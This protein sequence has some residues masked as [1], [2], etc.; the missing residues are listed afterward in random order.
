MS[1][2]YLSVEDYFDNSINSFCQQRG[3]TSEVGLMSYA[4]YLLDRIQPNE[5]AKLLDVGCGDGLPMAMI[6]KMRPDLKIDGLELSENL[7]ALAKENNPEGEIYTGNALD[8]ALPAGKY[9]TIFSF[10]FLQY[11]PLN[12]VSVVQQHLVK[13]IISGGGGV[14]IHCSIPDV[15]MQPISMAEYI[16]KEK[17]MSGWWRT[18]IAYII[19]RIR[20][21][22]IYGDGHGFWHDP[23]KLQIQLEQIGQT[24][25]LPG[26]VYYRFDIKQIVE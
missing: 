5:G 16:F 11:I 17:G 3:K 10:S 15:H 12:D 6:S 18:P 8:V 26:D 14:I 22:N 23:K 21:G 2:H 19:S 7:A 4:A 1:N 13:S 20:R 25:I 24:E 9:N